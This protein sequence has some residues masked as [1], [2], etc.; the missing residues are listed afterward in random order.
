MSLDTPIPFPLYLNF[1]TMYEKYPKTCISCFYLCLFC[2][3]L[4]PSYD[5]WGIVQDTHASV[6]LTETWK[7]KTGVSLPVPDD[8]KE[9]STEQKNR[10]DA[11]CKVSVLKK[12]GIRD[13]IA[14]PIVGRCKELARDPR[15]CI[16]V[17]SSIVTAESGGGNK[18]KWYNCLGVGQGRIK[19]ASYDA[20]VKDFITRY[21]KWW[22]KARSASFFYPSVWES[23]PSRYCTSEVSSW[24]AVGCPNGQKHAQSIWNKLTKK[25]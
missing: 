20:W 3:C 9:D 14:W 16:I 17:A 25:F 13:K 24:V 6:I 23:S 10:C 19:Y 18:C 12:I 1:Y 5:W 2:Y 8:R 22:Y 4:S 7:T 11:K 15:H 21:N